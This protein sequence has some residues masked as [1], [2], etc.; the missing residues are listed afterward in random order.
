M[1]QTARVHA[2]VTILML[3]CSMVP[4]HQLISSSIRSLIFSD[5]RASP[6]Q[7]L[8]TDVACSILIS[9]HESLAFSMPQLSQQRC[10]Y[11][12]LPYLV[13]YL[14]S[15]PVHALHVT[16]VLYSS[17]ITVLNLFAS[18]FLKPTTG[19][20]VHPLH[21]FCLTDLYKS[22]HSSPYLLLCFS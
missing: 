8:P 4:Q 7:F 21:C 1:H 10:E 11:E 20:G 9:V 16:D 13:R 5:T 6:E 22:S 18:D 17:T 3:G 2:T 15:L 19:D 14:D 12:S